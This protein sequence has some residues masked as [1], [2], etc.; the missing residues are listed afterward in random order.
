[1]VSSRSQAEEALRAG[2]DAIVAQ[3]GKVGG[4]GGDVS[5]MVMVPDV[6]DMAGEVPVLAAGGIA[7]D[8][9]LAAALALGAQGMLMGTRFLASEEMGVSQAWKSRIVE[10]AASDAVKAGL[11]VAMAAHEQGRSERQHVR[12]VAVEGHRAEW[13]LRGEV[14]GTAAGEIERVMLDPALRDVSERA[15]DLSEVE[16][17][18]AVCAYALVRPQTSA[19]HRITFED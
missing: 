15:F 17:L 10:S 9:G 19:E 7:D 14:T 6:V 8:R 13:A 11:E 3:G 5:T 18:D 16:R 12:I 2:A 4:Q 1:M